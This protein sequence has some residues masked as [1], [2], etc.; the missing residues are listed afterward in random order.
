MVCSGCD[1]RHW[2]SFPSHRAYKSS[3]QAM[4][5]CCPWDKEYSAWSLPL[6]QKD[7]QGIAHNRSGQELQRWCQQGTS[8]K[9]EK[10]LG[11]GIRPRFTSC[12]PRNHSIPTF[13]IKLASSSN[14]FKVPKATSWADFG[15]R[16][17]ARVAAIH[18]IACQVDHT[19]MISTP[20]W[21]KTERQRNPM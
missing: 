4:V 15:Q 11:H 13:N 12:I 18:W 16:N 1:Q 7:L 2:C 10:A 6:K 5:R 8:R 21:L 20:N 9:P 17:A 19:A 14:G 3:A